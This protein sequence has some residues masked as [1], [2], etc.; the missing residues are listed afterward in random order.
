VNPLPGKPGYGTHEAEAWDMLE[1][2]NMFL[3]QFRSDLAKGVPI[4]D[5]LFLGTIR[6]WH[7]LS[8]EVEEMLRARGLLEAE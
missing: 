4:E 2:V 1:R 3:I 5:K 6:N 8:R 7:R